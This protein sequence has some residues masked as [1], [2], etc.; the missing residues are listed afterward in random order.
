MPCYLGMTG[1]SKL[2]KDVCYRHNGMRTP[3]YTQQNKPAE[4][5]LAHT[6]TCLR[7]CRKDMGSLFNTFEIHIPV[8]VHFD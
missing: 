2:S 7:P 3:A 6:M 5:S 1:P 8:D 4:V